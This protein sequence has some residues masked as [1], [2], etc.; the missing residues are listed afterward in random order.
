MER[1]QN[2]TRGQGSRSRSNSSGRNASG[3]AGTSRPRSGSTGSRYADNRS[4]QRSR[5]RRRKKNRVLRIFVVIFVLL[6]AACVGGAAYLYFQGRA[7]VKP[8]PEISVDLESLDSPY[9]ALLDV[10]SGKVI[11]SKRGDEVIYPASMTKVLTVL[12]AIEHIKN[13]DAKTTMSYDY[14]DELYAQDA[15]RAG[16]EPSE[17]V[18]IRDLLYGALLPSGAECC[19][20]LA[21][22]A[23]GSEA[24][25]VVL[26]NQKVQELGL[27][28]THFANSTGLHSDDQ[29]TTPR[30]MGLILREALGNRTFRKVFT[31][32]SYTAGTSDIHPEGFT[33]QST[34]FKNMES[35]TVIGGEILGGKTGYTQE[36]GHCLASLARI[37]GS[38]YILVT[39][40]W[41]ENPRVEQ[42][43]IN[44]AYLAYNLVGR[45]TGG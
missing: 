27:T 44:D 28:Q 16:F 36:A 11:G 6:L 13:L 7:W 18:V 32:K 30:E 14:Y 24:D 12:T 43:H 29:Y 17:E 10:S 21:I 39:A 45:A 20:Q 22:E 8:A 41:A 33:F 1:R 26:M 4:G 23:A 3:Y 9:A 5:K 19:E 37:D 25:M 42:Y 31:T 40:G 35:A 34:M 38:E 2:T 15:S